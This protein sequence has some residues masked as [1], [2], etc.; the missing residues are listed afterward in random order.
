MLVVRVDD[1]PPQPR[2]RLGRARPKDADPEARPPAVPR[3]KLTVVRPEPL[4]EPGDAEGWLAGL[5]AD[6]EAVRDE[7]AAAVEFANRAVHAHRAATLD[8]AIA[9]VTAGAALAVR[10]GFGTGDDLADGRYTEAIDVPLTERRRRAELLRPQER[11]AEV[12]GGKA[13]VPACELLVIRAR[14]DLDAGRTRE[15]ALQIR[16]GLEAMLAE[17]EALA[18]PDQDQDFAT[19]DERRRITGEAANEASP[20]SSRA[21]RAAEVAET[22]GIA[23][24]V[25]R[26]KRALG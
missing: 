3:T 5:R 21:D 4:G 19:L 26:R 1:A 9:D 14:A 10:V 15:A 13:S 23:E 20:E 16:V 8:P 11:V 22:L 2:R 17:R 12:L 24:R 6:S 25:L 18:A 7:I